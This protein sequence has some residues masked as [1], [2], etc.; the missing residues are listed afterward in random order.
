[1]KDRKK[2]VGDAVSQLRAANDASDCQ[3]G[4]LRSEVGTLQEAYERALSGETGVCLELFE[5]ER[6]LQYLRGRK[7]RLSANL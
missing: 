4:Q 5:L 6:E 2:R 1:V 3:L 7:E